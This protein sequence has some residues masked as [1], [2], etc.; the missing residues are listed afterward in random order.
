MVDVIIL[1]SDWTYERHAN[2]QI[3]GK[4]LRVPRLPKQAWSPLDAIHQAP[5][6]PVA[7][8]ELPTEAPDPLAYRGINGPLALYQDDDAFSVP[9]GGAAR[10]VPDRYT[11]LMGWYELAY[12][13]AHAVGLESSLDADTGHE[14]MWGIIAGIIGVIAALAIAY[15][16]I[17]A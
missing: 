10:P 12:Q 13:D 7:V 5:L 11:Y 16:V 4:A 3:E 15:R 8:D 17:G 9:L 2:A 6:E 14:M 1:H